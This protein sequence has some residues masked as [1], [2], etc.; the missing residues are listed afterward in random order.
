L[1]DDSEAWAPYEAEGTV[2]GSINKNQLAALTFPIV[3][4]AKA[5]MLE[6]Q[7]E[8]LEMR[9]ASALNENS[10]LKITRDTLLAQLM[11]GKLRVRDVE[12]TLEAVI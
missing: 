4:E 1:R 6:S 5:E 8:A 9:I 11:S 10:V 3:Q 12:K 7:L 2:F